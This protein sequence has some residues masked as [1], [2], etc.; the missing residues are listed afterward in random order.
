[1]PAR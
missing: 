1:L